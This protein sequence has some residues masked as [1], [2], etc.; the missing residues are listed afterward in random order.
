MPRTVDRVATEGQ[1][2]FVFPQ[3]G[4]GDKVIIEVQTLGNGRTAKSD[5][6][7]ANLTGINLGYMIGK[8]NQLLATKTE[9]ER[10][11]LVQNTALLVDELMPLLSP[12]SLLVTV[13]SVTINTDNDGMGRIEIFVENDWPAGPMFLNCHYGYSAA[14]EREDWNKALELYIVELLP[15]L[16]DISLS[17]LWVAAGCTIGA[18]LTA[19]GSCA[20]AIGAAGVV[21]TAEMAYIFHRYYQDGYGVIDINKYDCRFPLPGGFNHTY[22]LSLVETMENKLVPIIRASPTLQEV[23]DIASSNNSVQMSVSQSQAISSASRTN[24]IVLVML[25]LVGAYFIIGGDG[26]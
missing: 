12:S 19:G 18:A 26:S 23:G 14:A 7:T 15:L 13:R 1:T 16:V 9:E 6:V 17:I 5:R 2:E 4:N 25:V 3:V 10:V 8:M 20:L 24:G 22:A 21:F 11:T